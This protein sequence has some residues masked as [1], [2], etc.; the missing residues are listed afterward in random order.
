M[1]AQTRHHSNQDHVVQQHRVT[2]LVQVAQVIGME[3]A[4]AVFPT[5]QVEQDPS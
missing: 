5:W 2:W 3:M 1:S 4:G